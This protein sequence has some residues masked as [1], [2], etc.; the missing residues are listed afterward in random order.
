MP[1]PR[2]QVL[3]HSLTHPHLAPSLPFPPLPPR[4]PR[5]VADLLAGRKPEQPRRQRDLH[6]H[7]LH[8]RAQLRADPHPVLLGR[9]R[10]HQH[11]GGGAHR[12]RERGVGRR[13]AGDA[14]HGGGGHLVP[15]PHAAGNSNPTSS[16]RRS[17]RPLVHAHTF[18]PPRRVRHSPPQAASIVL[19]AADTMVLHFGEEGILSNKDA[20][21][22]FEL[23]NVDRRRMF[24]LTSLPRRLAAS[25]VS[26]AAAAARSPA[27]ALSRISAHGVESVGGNGTPPPPGGARGSNRGSAHGSADSEGERKDHSPRPPPNLSNSPGR[28]AASSHL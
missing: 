14:G 19:S 9:G 20:R 5:R 18:S 4:I 26:A 17:R 10:G 22:L 15:P 8:R 28:R 1:M 25:A 16:P 23:I 6:P 24:Q 7:E 27:R 11:A 2:L 12:A 21:A 3:A 13:G